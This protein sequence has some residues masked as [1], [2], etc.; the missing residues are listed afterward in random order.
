M[1]QKT[2]LVIVAAIIT[3]TIIAAIFSKFYTNT[4]TLGNNI[5]EIKLEGEITTGSGFLPIA[6]ANPETLKNLIEDANADPTVKAILLTINSPGGSPVASD[7][8]SEAVEDSK[9]TIVAYISESGASG[10]YWVAASADK[11]VAHPL[12]ITCSIGAFTTINDLSGLFE[13]IGLNQTTIKSG[14]LKDIGTS[15][16]S[17][18]E[19]EKE[20][21]QQLI[22][23]V[24]NAF[25]EHVQEKR[26]LTYSQL[27]QV[28]DGRPC[29]GK[30]AVEYGLIDKVGS[31]D[32]AVKLIEEIEGM[33]KS[34]LVEFAP[35]ED[36]F[37]NLFSA[38]L[39]KGFY[40][41]GRGLGDS[42]SLEN[43]NLIRS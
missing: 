9:K 41:M 35:Q 7:E 11:I 43:T 17:P 39:Q 30:D 21:F 36:I 37:G 40:L 13:K 16:R 34:N 2:F 23:D 22:N 27:S 12:S 29:L 6:T 32:D 14:E 31:K 19:K 33:E 10:A 20:L 4:I 25:V 15:S 5:A 24:N 42:I 26:N 8:I 1:V 28:K 18:T 38:S 3:I